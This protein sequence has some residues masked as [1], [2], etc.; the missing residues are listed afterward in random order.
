MRSPLLKLSRQPE[1]GYHA[2][3]GE[4]ML[5]ELTT[6]LTASSAELDGEPVG[7]VSVEN[8]LRFAAPVT[9][10]AGQRLKIIE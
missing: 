1:A 3:E 10:K 8:G 6:G 9:V 4:L 5:K 7:F 2:V